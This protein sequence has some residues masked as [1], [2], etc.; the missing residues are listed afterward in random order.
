MGEGGPTGDLPPG[1]SLLFSCLEVCLCLLV[2]QL[3][4]L[5]PNKITSISIVPKRISQYGDRLLIKVLGCLSNLTSLASPHGWYF[6]FLIT[7]LFDSFFNTLFLLLGA[8]SILPTILYLTTGIIK[9]TGQQDNVH[10]GVINAAVELLESMAND[11][12]SQYPDTKDQWSALMLSVLRKII[13]LSKNGE[14]QK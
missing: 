8:I 11:K 6:L 3:P 9:E 10:R 12:H 4:T 2:R 14:L 1:K 5:S 7:N 13:D